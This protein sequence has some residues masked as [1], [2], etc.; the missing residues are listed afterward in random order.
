FQIVLSQRFSAKISADGVS[1]Y[2]RLRAIN[3]SPY[4]FYLD[5][6][7]Y[8]DFEVVGASPETLV[9]VQDGTCET[10]PIAGTRP[11][12]KDEAEDKALAGELLADPKGRAEHL[13]LV[14][15]G[16]NDL[17]RVSAYGSVRMAR[18]MEIDPL[19]HVM[20]IVSVV[21]GKLRDDR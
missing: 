13:M 16:R 6:K 14:D 5:F 11:R 18:F 20:H 3:P 7:G 4:M 21:Q 17:G 15:L 19:S 9:K 1:I 8:G 10:K 12:G 2:R